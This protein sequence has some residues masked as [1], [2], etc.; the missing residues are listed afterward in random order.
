MEFYIPSLFIL[1]IAGLFTFLVIP[2]FTPMILAIIA[3]VCLIFT[4][5]HHRTLFYNEY[6]NMNWANTATMAAPYLVV[7]LVIILSI[8]YIILL[9]SSGKA[10][11]LPQPSMN[12][13]PPSTA[14]NSLTRAIGNGLVASKAAN[15]V[16]G[17]TAERSLLNSALSK[18]V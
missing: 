12:I 13:P 10:L 1:L 9:L 3:L 11:S 8:G 4:V 6:K 15:V 17:N 5:Y 2:R 14:T 7:G 18:G 16:A